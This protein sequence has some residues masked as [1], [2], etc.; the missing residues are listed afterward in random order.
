MGLPDMKPAL[1]RQVKAAMNSELFDAAKERHPVLAGHESLLSVLEA[2]GAP[3]RCPVAERDA[4]VRALIAEQQREPRPLWATVL[5]VAFQPMLRRLR[6]RLV[7]SALAGQDLD[8][9]VV[10]AF[11]ET[12]ATFPLDRQGAPTLLCVRQLT[13]RW[14]FRR[15]ALE[16]REQ[17]L[18]CTIEHADLLELEQR[19][20]D[21][22]C[23]RRW[24]ELMAQG[25]AP[26]DPDQRA[27]LE[28]FLVGLLGDRLEPGCLRLVIA[29]LVYGE[30]LRSL[31]KRTCP[32]LPPAE[33][34]RE[35]ARLKRRHSR[36]IATMRG[37]LADL[38]GPDEA[39]AL[40]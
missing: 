14:I 35:Q 17:A 25:G 7:C 6:G 27:Q 32:A 33:L 11:L 10:A 22:Q 2:L 31:V 34:D 30:R 26:P 37:L 3:G 12:V 24:P 39:L 15:L 40:S 5:L 36:T 21:E 16:Q 4:L 29:T 9:L 8:Q 38:R 1:R 28:A 19:R 13:A 18:V 20:Y 23:E